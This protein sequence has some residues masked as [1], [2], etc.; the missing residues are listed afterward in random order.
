M[1]Q[2]PYAPVTRKHFR[3]LMSIPCPIFHVHR[4]YVTTMLFL[5]AS[6]MLLHYEQMQNVCSDYMYDTVH[7]R[8]DFCSG[9][10]HTA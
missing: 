4:Y 7:Y 10:W 2:V 8:L 3:A 5:G 6:L 9:H 1:V